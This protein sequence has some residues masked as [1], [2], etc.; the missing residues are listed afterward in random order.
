MIRFVRQ[1]VKENKTITRKAIQ[2]RAREF[3]RDK[4]FKASKG[5]F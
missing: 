4:N 2:Q 1:M 5:W 3:S